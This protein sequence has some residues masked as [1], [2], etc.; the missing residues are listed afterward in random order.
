MAAMPC[1][2][3]INFAKYS[4]QKSPSYKELLDPNPKPKLSV[5][6]R[7]INIQNPVLKPCYFILQQYFLLPGDCL[8]F[9]GVKL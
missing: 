7:L 2:F 4:K 3:C 5:P 8:L 9:D 1:F 6:R